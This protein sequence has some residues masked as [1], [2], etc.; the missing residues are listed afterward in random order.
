[1]DPLLLNV[2]EG[3]GAGLF[4]V[5]VAAGVVAWWLGRRS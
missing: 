5:F 1:M 3:L 4:V 2:L